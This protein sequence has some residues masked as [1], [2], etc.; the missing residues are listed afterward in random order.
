MLY[1][2]L[3]TQ[4]GGQVYLDIG[5]VEL[6]KQ[7]GATGF[8]LQGVL[9]DGYREAQV[10]VEYIEA[11]V[12]LTFAD[13]G[14]ETGG[15]SDYEREELP[16]ALRR[17]LREELAGA[18]VWLEMPPDGSSYAGNCSLFAGERWHGARPDGADQVVAA[19][20]RARENAPDWTLR[21]IDRFERCFLPCPAVKQGLTHSRS[22]HAHSHSCLNQSVSA[23]AHATAGTGLPGGG[24]SLQG[25]A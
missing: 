8:V 10:L 16:D 17:A 20:P 21:A 2:D 14:W 13:R 4:D 6:L 15:A 19:A 22:Q 18:G 11:E 9:G 1:L 24:A 3:M 12:S 23:P 25:V 5:S 7:R